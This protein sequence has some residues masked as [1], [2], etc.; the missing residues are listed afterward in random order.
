MKESM[1]SIPLTQTDK[2]VLEMSR[3]EYED[4]NTEEQMMKEAMK[5]SLATQP[6]VGNFND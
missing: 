2:A 1:N 3:K 4:S 5:Q 6:P